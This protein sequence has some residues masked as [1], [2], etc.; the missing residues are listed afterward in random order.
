MTY[1]I[2]LI[3]EAYK[4]TNKRFFL[5]LFCLHIKMTNK[6]YQKHKGKLKKKHAKDIKMFLKK[7]FLKSKENL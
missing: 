3:V 6:Y 4:K 2:R 5:Q 7:K 1:M